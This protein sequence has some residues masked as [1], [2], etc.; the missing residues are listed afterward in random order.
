MVRGGCVLIPVEIGCG[1]CVCV[2]SRWCTT[3]SS[4]GSVQVR[5]HCSGRRGRVQRVN[6]VHQAWFNGG[7]IGGGESPPTHVVPAEGKRQNQRIEFIRLDPVDALRLQAG[8]EVHSVGSSCV[9]AVGWSTHSSEVQSGRTQSPS[10]SSCSVDP[11]ELRTFPE[12][13]AY[14][15]YAFILA[16]CRF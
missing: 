9:R 4:L 3:P 16:E 14:G 15:K 8:G 11:L 12:V 5:V 10:G 7:T 6:R 1:V 13:L 2:C